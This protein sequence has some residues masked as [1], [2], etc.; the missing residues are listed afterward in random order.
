MRDAPLINESSQSSSPIS[1]DIG[2]E[3]SL[4]IVD[5]ET[6]GPLIG[7]I[8]GWLIGPIMI[9]GLLYDKEDPFAPRVFV[10]VFVLIWLFLMN[11]QYFSY[12][13]ELKIDEAALCIRRST[14]NK[15]YKKVPWKEIRN[16]RLWILPSWWGG[17]GNLIWIDTLLAKQI[18][19]YRIGTILPGKYERDNRD[20]IFAEIQRK[21]SEKK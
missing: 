3:K 13:V 11:L 16:V 17:G 2:E 4:S 6:A 9:V 5:E 20:A 10:M 19:P 8:L 15:I 7:L 21:V 14:R 1:L 18:I 12:I